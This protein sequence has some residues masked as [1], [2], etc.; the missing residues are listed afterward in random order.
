MVSANGTTGASVAATSWTKACFVTG[1]IP[2]RQDHLETIAQV[3]KGLDVS[4]PHQRFSGGCPAPQ[5]LG[6]E[7]ADVTLSQCTIFAI[8][9][10]PRLG[11]LGRK[12]EERPQY[13]AQHKDYEDGDL[14]LELRQCSPKV[15]NPT[16]EVCGK[17]S[18]RA[19]QPAG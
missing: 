12:Q 1:A 18:R 8:T 7:L 9:P 15:E 19:P 4:A 16:R 14:D 11:K 2:M 3:G 17:Q 5:P 6:I 13:H 10:P